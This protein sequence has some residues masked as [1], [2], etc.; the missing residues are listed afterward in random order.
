MDPNRGALLDAPLRIGTRGSPL[1]LA[2]ANEVA[3]LLV[4]KGLAAEGAIEVIVIQTTG[5]HIV[6]RPLADTGLKGIFTKEIDLALLSGEIE[7]AVHSMKDLPTQISAGVALACLLPREDPRDVLLGASSIAGL[8]GGAIVGTG[9]PRRAAQVRHSRPDITVVNFRGNV[10][11]R[12]RKLGEGAADATLLAYAGLRRLGLDT[13]GGTVLEADELLPAAAQ[14]AVGV[15]ARASNDALRERLVALHDPATGQVVGCERALL[16]ALNGSCRTPI[17]ALAEVQS[18]GALL[19]RA[20]L[21]SVDGV[22]RFDTTRNGPLAD[23]E[24]MGEDAGN[25]LRASA[26]PG[27]SVWN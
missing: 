20:S 9:S 2:Q 8:P 22:Q 23:A 6:D 1:A 11:T 3:R 16:S 10:H 26:G 7:I 24:R 18:D 21:L 13:A 17:A 19:L 27:F 15:V 25:E 12:M 5:D 14:G 4:E